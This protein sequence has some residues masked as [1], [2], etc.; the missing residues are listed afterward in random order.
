MLVDRWLMHKDEPLE[1][2]DIEAGEELT[3]YRLA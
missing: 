2:Q 1:L 3:I